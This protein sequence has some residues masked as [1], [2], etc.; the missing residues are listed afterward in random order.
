MNILFKI[1]KLREAK[2]LTK[3]DLADKVGVN[4][5]TVYNWTD[6]NIKVSTLLKISD[7]FGVDIMYFLSDN[8]EKKTRKAKVVLE[9]N[10]DDVL[11]IDIKNR[12]LEIVK[13]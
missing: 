1:E 3:T 7:T 4:R 11:N 8:P 12:R 5:D 10:D 6:E 13:K 2:N 9:L